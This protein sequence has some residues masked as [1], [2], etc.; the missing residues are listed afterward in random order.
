ME[1]LQRVKYKKN[2]MQSGETPGFHASLHGFLLYS[3]VI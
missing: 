2:I 3:R 1:R